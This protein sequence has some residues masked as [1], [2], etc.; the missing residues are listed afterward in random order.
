MVDS[1]AVTHVCPPWFSPE[2]TLHKLQGEGPDL[3]TAT[4][5]TIRVYGFKWVYMVNNKD[6]A[7]VIPFYVCDVAQPILSATGLAEQ[8]FEIVLSEQPASN[9]TSKWI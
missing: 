5:D 1:G 7:I 4:D 6:Q 9:E 3:R 8:G 2:T